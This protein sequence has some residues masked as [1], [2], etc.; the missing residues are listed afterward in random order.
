MEGFV[1]MQE[2]YNLLERQIEREGKMAVAKKY[3]LTILA[4]VPLAQGVLAAKYVAGSVEKGSRASYIKEV[5]DQYVNEETRKCVE[6]LSEIAKSKGVSLPQLS[7]RMDAPQT[8]RAGS[9]DH[10]HH[11]NHEDAVSRRQSW[12]ARR[13]AQLT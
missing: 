6:Q 3:G 13:Q 9:D 8:G 12:S 2:P 11:R 10:P 1:S 4:Y 7:A 5:A